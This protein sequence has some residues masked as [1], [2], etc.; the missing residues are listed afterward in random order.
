MQK[1]K[2]FHLFI[3]KSLF[4]TLLIFTFLVASKF[5]FSHLFTSK[6]YGLGVLKA[7]DQIDILF[8]GSS[9]TRQSYDIKEIE[10][11]CKCSV[12]AI[13]YSGLDPYF[14]EPIIQYIKENYNIKRWVIEP[15]VFKLIAPPKISDSRLFTDA[16][17]SLKYKILKNLSNLNVSWKDFFNLIVLE[18]NETLASSLIMNKISSVYSYN[19]GYKNKVMPPIDLNE[20]NNSGENVEQF[21]GM[22]RNLLQINSILQIKDILKKDKVLYIDPPMP[23]PVLTHPLT[24]AMILEYK[25]I[26]PQYQSPWYRS[27]PSLAPKFFTDWNHLS[28]NGRNVYTRM[29]V[30]LLNKMSFLDE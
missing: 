18:N 12:K 9:H 14:M 26:L 6:H 21:Y 5:Y 25:S 3:I 19:G 17:P 20:F 1:E 24:T 13:S 29:I 28:T 16:P 8:I 11:S 15:Y 4:L 30:E 7:E 27:G 10:K 2:K 23:N 22:K